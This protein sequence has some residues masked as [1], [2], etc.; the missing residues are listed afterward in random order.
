MADSQGTMLL[1]Q[2]VASLCKGAHA[3]QFVIS[4]HCRPD[5]CEPFSHP[6]MTTLP[7]GTTTFS[8]PWNLAG[9]SWQP[10]ATA[11]AAAQPAT[12]S[13][14]ANLNTARYTLHR[15]LRYEVVFLAKLR[16]AI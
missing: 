2:Y 12:A 10:S 11:Q 6:Q 3:T 16:G 4:L 13:F 8:F 5:N 9:T 14:Y 7:A 1:H 15:T